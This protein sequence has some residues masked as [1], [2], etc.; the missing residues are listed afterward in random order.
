MPRTPRRRQASINL[1]EAVSTPSGKP[2][3]YL[4]QTSATRTPSTKTVL[5]Q[6]AR[7]HRPSMGSLDCSENTP[8]SSFYLP[9]L[10]ST[11]VSPSAPPTSATSCTETDLEEDH[12]SDGSTTSFDAV[13]A[14][15]NRKLKRRAQSSNDKAAHARIPETREKGDAQPQLTTRKLRKR[16]ASLTGFLQQ[17]RSHAA[18]QPVTPR[19]PS[20][21][22]V[23]EWMKRHRPSSSVDS[24][25][26]APLFENQTQEHQSTRNCKVV[27]ELASGSQT[28]LQ[29]SSASSTEYSGDNCLPVR[30]LPPIKLVHRPDSREQLS[31]RQADFRSSSTGQE[32]PRSYS[33][34]TRPSSYFTIGASS[35]NSSSP[36]ERLF[37]VAN[38]G[39]PADVHRRLSLSDLRIPP[40]ITE[41]Q[42]KIEQE[43]QKVKR[44]K[45]GVEGRCC[46]P[47][48]PNIA[49]LL[50]IF[51]FNRTGT[52]A[53]KIQQLGSPKRGFIYQEIATGQ[54]C[55]QD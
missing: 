33:I 43:L 51:M 1:A 5:R 41:K 47:A 13:T 6:Q 11:E 9:A 20:V 16:P 19:S 53:G 54:V 18:F 40:R 2:S 45:K 39:N 31:A 55:R 14:R 7:A 46:F 48:S 44:F 15:T 34:S 37:R 38:G 3:A 49:R 27:E 35:I 50:R 42:Q 4:D 29:P 28:D 10:N 21:T 32:S 23:P 52:A 36:G 17:P 30:P 12:L 25:I 24:N 22:L 26:S 8:P